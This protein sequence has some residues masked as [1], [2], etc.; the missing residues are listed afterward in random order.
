M[1]I[2][3]THSYRHAEAILEVEYPQH[4]GEVREV[5]NRNPRFSAVGSRYWG[6]GNQGQGAV[7][8]VT[9]TGDRP[10]VSVP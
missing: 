8:R 9:S 4:T 2:A 5:L 7:E 3:Q 10:C 1:R 6:H